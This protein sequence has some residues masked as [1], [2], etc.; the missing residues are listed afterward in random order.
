MGLQHNRLRRNIW[1]ETVFLFSCATRLAS[2][3]A[4]W[5]ATMSLVKRR[6]AAAL[7]V[8]VAASL[9]TFLQ[10]EANHETDDQISEDA[11]WNAS[12]SDLT[13]ISQACKNPAEP[14][15]TDCFIEQMGG[16][17]S[18]DAVGFTQL[19]ASQKSSRLGYL[20][21]MKESGIVDLGYVLYPDN[22]KSRQGWVL[23]NGVPS[24][25]DVDDISLLP[26]SAMEKD[27]EFLALRR[28]HPQLLLTI[29]EDERG[30]ESS[31][32]AEQ[33]A[34]GGEMFVVPYSLQEP[35]ASCARVGNALFGFNFDSTGKFLG[36]KFLKVE[37]ARP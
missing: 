8:V 22:A 33:L 1:L 14:D 12:D 10:V 5:V 24:I 27:P 13:A 11:V 4:D 16:Y 19:L 37:S 25:V 2:A 20:A 3:M 32:K 17:A 28:N 30:A 15:H 35:C 23:L 21:G 29:G 36:V 31:P 6:I 9:V 34:D 7:A 18:S 26:K